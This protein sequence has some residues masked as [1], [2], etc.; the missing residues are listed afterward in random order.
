MS[1]KLEKIKQKAFKSLIFIEQKKQYL[2]VD[3]TWTFL[4]TSTESQIKPYAMTEHNNSLVLLIS[5]QL[6]HH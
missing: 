6:F 2:L 4:S 1:T 5:L 3:F